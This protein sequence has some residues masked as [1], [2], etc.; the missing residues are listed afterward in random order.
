L[1]FQSLKELWPLE[2]EV[3]MPNTL[4]LQLLMSCINVL[5]IQNVH[6]IWN[7]K[8]ESSAFYFNSNIIWIRWCSTT[9]PRNTKT[10]IYPIKKLLR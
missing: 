4:V 1:S 6:K 10:M 7:H 2:L 8:S 9:I 5:F 3:L